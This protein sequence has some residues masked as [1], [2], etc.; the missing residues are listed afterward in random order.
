VRSRPLGATGFQVSEIGFGAWGLGADMWR[1]VPESEA[2]AALREAVDQGITFVDTALA[3]GDGHSE[4]LVGR[5]LREEI[6]SGRVVVATKVPP[7]NERWPGSAASS[8]TDVFS[9]KHLMRSTERSLRNLDVEALSLQQL[10]VWHDAWLQDPRWEEVRDCLVRLKQ[11]GKVL[12]WGISINDH[13]PETAMQVLTDALFETAQ[14]IYNIYDRSP[15]RTLFPFAGAKPLGVIARVPFDEGSL[16]GEIRAGTTFPAGDW[17]AE[18]FAGDRPAE[19][20][21]R[22]RAL[23]QLLGAEAHT[24][25][26]LALRFCLSAPAVSTVIPGMRRPAHVRANA[27]AA[28]RGPLSEG[29][30]ARLAA[31]A[32]EKNWYP[33]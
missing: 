1:G 29:L 12:H 24:L 19:A 32:W 28:G 9:V 31:H 21:R 13:A 5:V 10:H 22:A 2:Q 8:L 25:P 4:Q 27:A 30:L 20:E 15:E 11:D 33:P 17:R 6:R 14:V 3:Y 16:T 18:Y 23:A 26:E 7:G